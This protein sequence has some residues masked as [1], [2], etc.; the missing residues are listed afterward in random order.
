MSLPAIFLTMLQTRAAFAMN[1]RR[2]NDA[3][4]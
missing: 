3:K 1:E 4:E 2:P